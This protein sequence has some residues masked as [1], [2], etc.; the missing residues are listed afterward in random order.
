QRQ[1]IIGLR[2]RPEAQPALELALADEWQRRDDDSNGRLEANS[3]PSMLWLKPE[4]HDRY[5]QRS[6]SAAAEYQ[7]AQRSSIT[8]EQREQALALLGTEQSLRRVAGPLCEEVGVAP[9]PVALPRA[10]VRRAGLSAR[11]FLQAKDKTYWRPG[12]SRPG[13]RR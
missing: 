12:Q 9:S 6:S 7:P 5:A 13:Q 8:K 4:Y 11:P 10:R 3:Y 2:P 1:L